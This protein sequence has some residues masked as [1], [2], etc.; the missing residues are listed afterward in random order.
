M[1]SLRPSLSSWIRNRPIPSSNTTFPPIFWNLQVREMSKYLS[2]AAKKRIP[3]NAKF[4]GKGFYKGKGATKQGTFSGRAGR[5]VLDRDLLLDL[6]V[7]D[8]TNFKVCL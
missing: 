7:P 5:F 3:L 8:L 6:V 1:F 4:A 2:R